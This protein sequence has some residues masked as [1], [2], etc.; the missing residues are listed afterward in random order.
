MT[1]KE[2]VHTAG[3][4]VA[5]VGLKAAGRYYGGALGGAVVDAALN[6]K[7][8]QKIV[9]QQSK[10][11]NKNPL[12]RIVLAKN[13]EKIGNIKPVVNSVLDNT[14]NGGNPTAENLND[15]NNSDFYNCC[16]FRYNNSFY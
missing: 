6:T 4:D 5:E 12:T 7:A 14:S 13:Q 3:K 11:M 8:G 2:K 1:N 15:N 16:N 9:T 10:K